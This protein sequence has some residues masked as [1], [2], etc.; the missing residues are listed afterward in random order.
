MNQL[1]SARKAPDHDT[2]RILREL[3]ELRE[4]LASLAGRHLSRQEL[5]DRWNISLATLDRRVK[6]GSAPRPINGKWP[7]SRVIEWENQQHQ[8]AA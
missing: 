4:L 7:L 8:N 1:D 6:S 2:D 5:A 3:R